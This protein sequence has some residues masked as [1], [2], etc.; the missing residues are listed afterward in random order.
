MAKRVF[1]NEDMTNAILDKLD[2]L[3][4][5]Q[6][7]NEKQLLKILTLIQG[8]PML[9]T[10]HPTGI[11]NDI[12]AINERQKFIE[13]EVMAVVNWF[14]DRSKR[15]YLVTINL[16]EWGKFI[17]WVAAVGGAIVGF[18]AWIGKHLK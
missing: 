4:S 9:S 12:K 18:F 15:R 7:S 13:Q 1:H 3:A 17:A 14:K 16:I 11:V 10:I 8:D 5:Q 6:E 2:S